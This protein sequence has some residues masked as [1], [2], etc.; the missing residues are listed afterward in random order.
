M[1]PFKFA[2][3]SC[4]SDDDTP[5]ALL[6]KPF[7]EAGHKTFD[8][9]LVGID[10]AGGSTDV[11]TDGTAEKGFWLLESADL[12]TLSCWHVLEPKQ[13]GDLEGVLTEIDRSLFSFS[14]SGPPLLLD[15]IGLLVEGGEGPAIS[16]PHMCGGWQL[17]F[18]PMLA[19]ASRDTRCACCSCVP[20]LLFVL[21]FSAKSPIYF[22]ANP[23]I[24]KSLTTH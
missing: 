16:M 19:R 24:I 6:T 22:C 3:I 4:S 1:T 20:I 2:L 9:K 18:E 15:T 14:L 12:S 23:L 10:V 11:N 5:S 8:P 21:N 17:L 13:K 7:L